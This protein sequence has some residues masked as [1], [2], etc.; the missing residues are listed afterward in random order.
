[1]EKCCETCHWWDL[2]YNQPP[3][4]YK[5][6]YCEHYFWQSHFGNDGTVPFQDND[7]YLEVYGDP[8]I[9]VAT[10]PKFGCCHWE[11]TKIYKARLARKAEEYRRQDLEREKRGR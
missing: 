7:V 1:M 6:R 4:K 11:T 10:G 2:H 5:S 3:T 8:I 9:Q